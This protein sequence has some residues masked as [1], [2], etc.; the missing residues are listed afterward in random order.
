MFTVD[1]PGALPVEM[2][3][4]PVSS[5][6]NESYHARQR[7]RV[8]GAFRRVPASAGTLATSTSTAA[9]IFLTNT[10]NFSW[11]TTLALTGILAYTPAIVFALRKIKK[12]SRQ[13]ALFHDSRSTYGA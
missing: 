10:E 11:T 12:G 8:D 5:T 7:G 2:V 6:W 1:D 13:A 3:Q 4:R 9:A